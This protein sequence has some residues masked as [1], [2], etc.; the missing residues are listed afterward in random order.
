M[1]K[2]KQKQNAPAT[3]R[4]QAA[5]QRPQPAA[6]NTRP[7]SPAPD[8]SKRNEWLMLL[9][10]AIV[11][12]LSYSACLDNQ[13]TNWDDLGYIISDRF[14]KNDTLDGYLHIFSWDCQ[15]M[16]NYHPLTILFYAFEYTYKGLQPFIY[17]L[18]SVLSHVVTTIAV[19]F[20][21]KKLTGRPVAAL[22]ATLLFGVHPMHVESIAWAAGRKDILYSF[23][24]VMGL[25]AYL[26]YVR[27]EKGK[28]M[29]WYIATI[30]L[31]A[32]S[33]LCKSVGVTFPVVLL[34]IDLYE[35]RKFDPW[36]LVD[37]IP[38]FVLSFTFGILSV[39]AQHKVGALG[40]LD[41]HFTWTEHISLGC[42]AF[43]TYLWKL[44]VPAGMCNFYPYPLKIGDSMPGTYYVFPF[45]A[46]AFAFLVWQFG[47]KNKV[48]IFG[49]G[50]FIINIALLLQFIPVGGAI[51]SDRYTYL[52]YLGFFIIAG[53]FI[54]GY[55]EQPEKLK[56]GKLMVGIMVGYCLVLGFVSNERCKDW[57]DS[58]TLWQDDIQKH[59]EAPVGYFYLGQEY[60]TRYEIEGN[61]NEKKNLGDSALKYFNES[62]ARK[63]D[64]INPLICIADLQRDYNLVD[65][66]ITTY[67]KA[68]TISTTNESVYLGLGVLYTIKQKYD[69]AGNFFHTALSLKP[70]FFPEGYSNYANYLDIVGKLDSSLITYAIAIQ[71]NPDAYIPY[72]NRARIFMRKKMW[73]DAIKDCTR[74][75][76]A[77]PEVGDLY[78]LRAQ[79]YA[80]KGNMAQAQQDA[81]E[82]QKRGV[83]VDPNVFK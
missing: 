37:K 44:V 51:L 65:D 54:S 71:Q 1:A 7:A 55:F 49:I 11:T 53:W 22:I 36:L 42:Y 64:Y 82:A 23:F 43:C 19:Y 77:K 28:G 83:K 25:T 45:L 24:Y 12:F 81:Q 68:L 61:A 17:H 27:A 59:P 47:R 79:C 6:R 2:N 46:L 31:F 70:N 30:L 21:V 35:R 60:F 5:P 14:I 15:V 69:S 72:M 50:F 48:V 58:V 16:G 66:A 57:Y 9:G 8:K 80:R 33:L 52:P 29:H 39:W 63:P 62:V 26:N 73:D 40:T 32:L 41:A 18:D 75:I 3:S 34:L 4:P 38:Y 78:Y 20:F 74:G 67:R 13:L 56:T 76:E 10:I